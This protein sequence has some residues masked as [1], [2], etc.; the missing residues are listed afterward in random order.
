MSPPNWH[1]L[2]GARA[3]AT[4]R[5]KGNTWMFF[6]VTIL[7]ALLQ[8]VVT[9]K[10]DNL[11]CADSSG[12]FCISGI[13]G[14]MN[15][16][17]GVTFTLSSAQPGVGYLAWG[18]G[19]NAMAG[20]KIYGVWSNG[21]GVYS[22][23]R[24]GLNP[25]AVTGSEGMLVSTPQG[26]RTASGATL[27]VSF[28]RPISVAG[29]GGDVAIASGGQSYIWA[30]GGAPQGQSLPYH[31]GARG[32]FSSNDVD[33]TAV[34][35][36][37]P[38]TDSP[39]PQTSTDA[40]PPDTST[41]ITNSP[42]STT[43]STTTSS[44]TSP[45]ASM[46]PF[47]SSQY[48][49]DSGGT[50]CVFAQADTAASMLTFTLQ[51]Y[52]TTGWI[53]LGIG[54]DRM[55]RISG[56]FV[57]WKNSTGGVTF[58]PRL[59]AG[60][61]VPAVNPNSTATLLGTIPVGPI[62][63]TAIAPKKFDSTTTTT[64]DLFRFSFRLP[65]NGS[66]VSLTGLTTLIWAV[67]IA[68]PDVKVLDSATAASFPMHD[69]IGAF[70][71]NLQPSQTGQLTIGSPMGNQPVVSTSNNKLTP[72]GSLD[73]NTP[74]S[75][76][77]RSRSILIHAVTMSI[78]WSFLLYVSI[79]FARG[80]HAW[81]SR[82]FGNN[83]RLARALQISVLLFGIKL[84][85]VIGLIVIETE[86]SVPSSGGMRFMSS[87]H[88][89][90][91]TLLAIFVVPVLTGLSIAGH[92]IFV[93]KTMKAVENE[94]RRKLE[95]PMGL[96]GFDTGNGALTDGDEGRSSWLDVACRLFMGCSALLSIPTLWMGLSMANAG[97]VSIAVVIGVAIIGFIVVL[98]LEIIALRKW[99]V[100]SKVGGGMLSDKDNGESGK[101]V[102]SG[103]EKFDG[104][105][106]GS[107][108]RRAYLA[109]GDG[110]AGVR[111]TV[112][113][114]VNLSFRQTMVVDD[115]E[116]GKEQQQQQQ[117]Q[118]LPRDT[119]MTENGYGDIVQEYEK[120]WPANAE[121]SNVGGSMARSEADTLTST[122]ASSSN[123]IEGETHLERM[124]RQVRDTMYTQYTVATEADPDTLTRPFDN[125][126][127]NN[128][129]IAISSSTAATPYNFND[130][131][132]DTIYTQ[133]T[134]VTESTVASAL[135]PSLP[136]STGRQ[137]YQTGTLTGTGSRGV[138]GINAM[139]AQRQQ[140]GAGVGVSAY[141]PNL[142]DSIH[143]S[144][145]RPNRGGASS[146]F[147]P[148]QYA[149]LGNGAN[150]AV[151]NDTSYGD[152]KRR[153]RDDLDLLHLYRYTRSQAGG[154]A[155]N[156]NGTGTLT[157]Y[158]TS[159]RGR[160]LDRE[161]AL[162]R[163]VIA[164]STL[165]I[166][167]ITPLPAGPVVG[168]AGFGIDSANSV[169]TSTL[170]RKTPPP[171]QSSTLTRKTPPPPAQAT[172]TRKTP[173]PTQATLTRKTPPPTQS[174]MTRQ[175]P[176]QPVYNSTVVQQQQQ[177]YQQY[178]QQ[179]PSNTQSRSYQ[180]KAGASTSLPRNLS[181][182]EQPTIPQR[183]H[184]PYRPATD[185][186]S[187]MMASLSRPGPSGGRNGVEQQ[188]QQGM[189]MGMNMGG[190]EQGYGNGN[191]KPGPLP[192]SVPSLGRRGGG[193]A[194]N[195]NGRW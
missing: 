173:P 23:F 102:M 57:G 183:R 108:K 136:R 161:T 74:S 155:S 77:T 156:G 36:P 157:G 22:G 98:V 66:S 82:I 141:R 139:T 191:G 172:L 88:A 87:V 144:L 84:P 135:P 30:T 186:P 189:S 177:P 31:G 170:S 45:T 162:R 59:A 18:L 168:N 117:Q 60:H 44:T 53:G 15:G 154:N 65:L 150:V 20:A 178:Q 137:M 69:V 149:K 131:S 50:F 130:R 5:H 195:G 14:S 153:S 25:Y 146:N 86:P 93:R 63:S 26:A 94:K 80:G 48:C 29:D 55:D 159:S 78:A 54:S 72:P 8:S 132:R 34:P 179:G 2:T 24:H 1:D 119:Y 147:E 194:V 107:N 83:P 19:S 112:V 58:S 187:T 125:S 92:V 7:V 99:F 142:R 56:Y 67:S 3:G 114:E 38:T 134:A 176:T 181:N 28:W 33:F 148:Y 27:V 185:S 103:F 32:A 158:N 113:T 91:G 105:V 79:I 51:S 40:P 100:S 124:R 193:N 47:S 133:Y 49:A 145:E 85:T 166:P 163:G 110:F 81:L 104:D 143:M 10:A 17:P 129:P 138:A 4:P 180:N 52:V 71:L 128:A 192:S 43:D 13:P 89:V 109:S 165:V 16:V 122:G 182:T 75:S 188:Q 160:S 96:R 115:V 164:E 126:A 184:P 127:N 106:Y 62:N 167:T 21:F 174:T 70:T 41:S 9:V 111:D 12:T 68:A 121:S 37:P 101:L 64:T 46:N 6:M 61:V 97:V 169:S 39:P 73:P 35:A 123:N 140:Q 116:K 175:T 76:S 120:K 118:S 190:Q 151:S 42:T 95:D 171:T 90:L 11:Y 152:D